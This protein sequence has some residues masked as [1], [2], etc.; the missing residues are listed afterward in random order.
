MV[1]YGN[2]M[3]ESAVTSSDDAVEAVLREELVQGD[4]MLQSAAPVMRH[5]LSTTRSAIFADEIVARVRGGVEDIARQLLGVTDSPEHSPLDPAALDDLLEALMAVPGLVGHLHALAVEWQL[6][7]RF[8]A[9]HA[10]DPVVPPLLEALLASDDATT[11]ALAMT[12]LAAQAR[13]AQ[14]QRRMQAPLHE[15]PADLLHGVLLAWRGIVGEGSEVMSAER[16]IRAEFDESRTRLGL[17]ARLVTGMG[18][19]AIAALSLQHAGVAIFASAV[20]MA[21]GQD[22]EIAILATSSGQ[23]LRLALMLRAAGV[24]PRAIEEQLVSLHAEVGLPVEWHRLAPE[25]ATEL[26]AVPLPNAGV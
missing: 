17:I 22:R 6:T 25:Q 24:K 4:A 1:R 13:F 23:S 26:L 9:R 14:T 7:E 5:I 15:L 20:A 21:S 12:S 18:S 3:I 19:G 10:L 16:A 2:G 8:Q 11:S